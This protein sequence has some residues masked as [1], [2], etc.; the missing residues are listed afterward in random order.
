MPE[1]ERNAQTWVAK[2][3]CVLSPNCLFGL[4]LEKA[5]GRSLGQVTRVR[6]TQPQERGTLSPE[7]P[8]GRQRLFLT[9]LSS[10][11]LT[12]PSPASGL[13]FG[14]AG[15]RGCVTLARSLPRATA[16]G[17]FRANERQN[18]VSTTE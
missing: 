7:A 6:V 1:L 10:F 16:H 18:S 5:I 4:S 17:P 8:K 12:V 9:P 3:T 2:K 11:S 14:L 13:V 15:A